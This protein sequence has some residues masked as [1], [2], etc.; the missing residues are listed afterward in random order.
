MKGNSMQDIKILVNGNVYHWRDT[1]NRALCDRTK[2]GDLV[3]IEERP[4]IF[5]PMWE[6]Q[7]SRRNHDGRMVI[8]TRHNEC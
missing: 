1:L 5:F 7:E 6:M 4:K 8:D 2:G 3:P